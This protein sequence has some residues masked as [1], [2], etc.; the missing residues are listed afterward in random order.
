MDKLDEMGDKNTKFFHATTIQRRQRNRISMIK[1]SDTNWISQPD[2]IK[3]EVMN[4]FSDLFRSE[5]QENFSPVLEQCPK[6]VT[7]EMNMILS[8]E[9][10]MEE[11]KKATFQLGDAKAPGPDGLNGLFYQQNW[12][13]L[14]IDIF[15]EVKEFFRTGLMSPELNSTYI[16]LIP[17]VQNPE[18]L[19]QFRPSSLCNFGYKIIAKILANRLKPLLPDI[20]AEEQS[21]FVGGKQIQDNILVVQEILHQI[22]VRKRRKKF[23][24]ILKL[25]I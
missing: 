17:K 21:A 18:N 19:E 3:Q 14:S 13:T 20:I 9:V 24:A 6:V 15:H 11:V 7:E 22:R 4:F 23:Q 12:E 10:N 2:L 5:G 25:D 1:G 8:A 16:S